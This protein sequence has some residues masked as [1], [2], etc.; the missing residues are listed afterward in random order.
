[1]TSVNHING[2]NLRSARLIN[3]L[4]LYELSELLGISVS[5]LVKMEAGISQPN[6]ILIKQLCCRLGILPPFLT[7]SSR[8]TIHEDAIF[9]VPITTPK[10]QAT[11][12]NSTL[13]QATAYLSLY[14][15]LIRV[16]KTQFRFPNNFPKIYDA[17]IASDTNI[18]QLADSCRFHWGLGFSPIENITTLIERSGGI[19]TSFPNLYSSI[20]SMSITYPHPIIIINHKKTAYQVRFDI[21]MHCGAIV[22]N[23]FFTSKNISAT[24][25]DLEN[26]AL[27]LLMPA[28]SFRNEFVRSKP[29][30]YWPEIESLQQR[31][32]VSKEA[33]IYRAFQLKLIS[34]KQLKFSLAKL[35]TNASIHFN[36]CKTKKEQPHFISNQIQQLNKTQALS[37]EVIAQHLAVKKL[38]LTNLFIEFKNALNKSA[39]SS[40]KKHNV[41]SINYTRKSTDLPSRL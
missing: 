41:F 15:E 38:L 4:N 40:P 6:N 1:M 27:A 19:V 26:F 8:Y 14:Y 35:R 13:F 23:F 7:G 30:I 29:I 17:D 3:Q 32:G 20:D 16:L 11:S 24:K 28:C 31:W 37:T 18:E 5:T 25:Q 39:A 2:N 12:N 36:N 33:V 10:S 9:Y 21:A 22:S 34:I